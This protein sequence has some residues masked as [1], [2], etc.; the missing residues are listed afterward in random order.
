VTYLHDQRPRLERKEM[1]SGGHMLAQQQRAVETQIKTLVNADLKEICRA[2][3]W[4][5][6][7]TKAQLQSRC[8]S[9][10]WHV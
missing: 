9:S 4:Q 1:A 10:E 3:G 6:S 7:G 5:V 2:W 8:T